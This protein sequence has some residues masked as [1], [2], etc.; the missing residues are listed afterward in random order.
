MLFT[1]ALVP[2]AFRLQVSAMIQESPSKFFLTASGIL[3]PRHAAH[4]SKTPTAGVLMRPAFQ[5]AWQIV[6]QWVW[7]EAPGTGACAGADA[8][9]HDRV[10]SSRQRDHRGT[11]ACA[12][13]WQ[14]FGCLALES[15]SFLWAGLRPPTR[16]AAALSRWQD[17]A[18]NRA[19]PRSR[20]QS[21]RALQ[22]QDTRLSWLPKASAL[23]VA[24]GSN[25]KTTSDQCPAASS[26]GWSHAAALAR[27]EPES[28]PAR[29]H[30]ARAAP[31]H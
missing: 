22:R 3:K 18:P 16:R 25:H 21:A 24:R 31:T 13:L 27:L 1:H 19:A 29:L 17:V 11:R 5:E 7:N 4:R 28:A 10:C 12:R 15:G 26:P 8:A 14:A 30:A 20:W 2:S 9:A 6:S 23:S